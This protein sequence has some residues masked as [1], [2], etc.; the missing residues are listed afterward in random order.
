[1]LKTLIMQSQKRTDFTNEK[2]KVWINSRSCEGYTPLLLAAYRGN[3]DIIKELIKFGADY[4]LINNSGLSILHMA[5]QGN[6]PSVIVY[7]MEKYQIDLNQRDNVG[8]T[9]LHWAC[10]SGS[11]DAFNYLVHYN[12]DI[13]C[14]DSEGKTPLHLAI[15][16][17][18]SKVIKKGLV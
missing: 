16:Y 9:A 8:S 14:Q 17:G 12:V 10:Y 4:S 1:M 13:N 2:K 7:F 11:I 6:K 15:E 5:A 3:I 18:I